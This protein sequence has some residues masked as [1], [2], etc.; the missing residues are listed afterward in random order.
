MDQVHRNSRYPFSSLP[1]R[2]SYIPFQAQVSRL[3]SYLALRGS[4]VQENYQARNQK[5]A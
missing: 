2:L 5:P 3:E 4:K 1:L